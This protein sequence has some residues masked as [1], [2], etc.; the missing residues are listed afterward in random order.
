MSRS[1]MTAAVTE[2]HCCQKN[3]HK[4]HDFQG[5]LNLSAKVEKGST[6]WYAVFNNHLVDY[7][8]HMP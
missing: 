2:R 7:F 5:Q 1:Y 4:I 3:I 8:G 6:F